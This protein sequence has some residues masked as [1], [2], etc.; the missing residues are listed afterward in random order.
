MTLGVTALFV[1]AFAASV[2]PPS[3]LA[4]AFLAASVAVAVHRFG[5]L[6]RLQTDVCV[7]RTDVCM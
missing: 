5:G 6:A 3:A 7:P 4:G 2:V 1:T